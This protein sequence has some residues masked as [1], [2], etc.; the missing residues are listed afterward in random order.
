MTGLANALPMDMGDLGPERGAHDTIDYL[1]ALGRLIA[2]YP[3]LSA[4]RI[5]STLLREWEVYTS[6]RPHTIPVGVEAG[7]REMLERLR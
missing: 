5:E 6:G 4:A 3:G 7:T 1:E 2:D